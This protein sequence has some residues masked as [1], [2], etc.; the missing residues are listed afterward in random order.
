MHHPSDLHGTAGI[1]P[2]IA[3]QAA[4]EGHRDTPQPPDISGATGGGCL[5]P[6]AFSVPECQAKG[7][8]PCRPHQVGD[9]EE[10]GD[11]CKVYE[12]LLALHITSF[13]LGAASAPP[14]F[15]TRFE[16]GSEVS[17]KYKGVNSQPW[18]RV[19]PGLR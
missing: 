15:F 2:F 8:S 3:L 14:L 5:V 9:A 19:S 18:H 7:D 17:G 13:L 10:G 16:G 11:I 4:K 1:V 12:K 6:W